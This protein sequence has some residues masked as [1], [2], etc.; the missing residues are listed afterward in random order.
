[1]KA[2][3]S[4]G[5][6]CGRSEVCRLAVTIDRLVGWGDMRE[7]L[8]NVRETGVLSYAKHAKHAQNVHATA[9]NNP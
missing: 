9:Q 7:M 6:L 8:Q 2:R 1:M 5:K 3:N 4:N